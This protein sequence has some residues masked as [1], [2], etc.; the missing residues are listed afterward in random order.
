LYK[1][2]FPGQ[3]PKGLGGASQPAR[4]RAAPPPRE[5]IDPNRDNI[6][7]PPRRRREAEEP[8]YETTSTVKI[9]RWR[10]KDNNGR[11]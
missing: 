9:G 10:E 8:E 2:Y 5:Y 1:Y 7:A 6:V 3:M 11:R 4:K